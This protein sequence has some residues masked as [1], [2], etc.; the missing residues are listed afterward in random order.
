M[1][2]RAFCAAAG[3]GLLG[4]C[5]QLQEADD[6]SSG[7]GDGGTTAELE[8]TPRWDRELDDVTVLDGTFLGVASSFAD[9]VGTTRLERYD[10]DGEPTWTSDELPDPYRFDFHTH[11][12]VVAGG[13]T[14]AAV[15]R[16][17]H[18]GRVC[19]F[20][21]DDGT[22]RWSDDVWLD[23]SVGGWTLAA[24][25]DSLY[26]A[27]VTDQQENLTTV[28]GYALE[29]GEL[30]WGTT[31]ELDR[32]TGAL[33]ADGQ[34]TVVGARHGG[35]EYARADL[36]PDTGVASERLLDISFPT[37]AVDPDSGRLYFAQD[38]HA[39]DLERDEIEWDRELD[40]ALNADITFEDGTIYGSSRSGWVLAYD[41]TDGSD[42]WEARI[43][44]EAVGTLWVSDG[45]VWAR[46]DTGSV[47]ALEA[48]S[49]DRL[50]ERDGSPILAATN[51]QVVI[52]NTAYA[53]DAN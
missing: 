47:Y 38:L 9:D 52:G 3:V 7:D 4:G 24:G 43:D 45:I 5:L 30:E 32:V 13:N 19:A 37:N 22:E 50:L 39:Y 25:A 17:D 29:S 8:L 49:G 35:G 27:A 26:V 21:A 51:G 36:D 16:D 44:G 6:G 10:D 48:A 20:A 23:S 2:R 53:V 46:S 31:V 12:D 1:Y 18:D 15:A 11:D 40:R 14:V 34:V 42:A 41:A 28:R 33:I